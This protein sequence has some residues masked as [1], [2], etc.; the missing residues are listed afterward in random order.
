[1]KTRNLGGDTT[2]SVES[3]GTTAA[4]REWE[5]IKAHKRE[6]VATNG[7]QGGKYKEAHKRE[8]VVT[9]SPQGGKNK[10]IIPGNEIPEHDNKI[11]V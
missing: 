9:N 3:F 6:D 11:I 8:D 4:P 5:I 2:S 10:E 7:P 1:M